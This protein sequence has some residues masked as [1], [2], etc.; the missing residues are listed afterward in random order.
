MRLL[1]ACSALVFLFGAVTAAWGAAPASV[2]TPAAATQLKRGDMVRVLRPQALFFYGKP[3][4]TAKAGA[5]MEVLDV[6]PATRQI[7][8]AVK[9][10]DRVIAVSLPLDAVRSEKEAVKTERVEQSTA[11]F[12]GL[13]PTLNVQLSAE[14]LESLRKEP[15][16][17]V[18]GTIEEAGVGPHEHLGIKLKGSAGSFQQVDQRPGFSINCSKFDGGSRFHGLRRFQLNNSVQDGTVLNELVSGEMA[19]AAGIPASRCT[20]ALVSINGRA[21][22][23]YVLKEGFTE[24]FLSTFFKQTDGHLY[25]GGFVADIQD[26]MELDRGDPENQ[27]ALARLNTALKE[28]DPAKQFELLKQVV[29]VDAYLRYLAMEDILCHWDG[30]SYNRNNYRI[31]ENPETGRFCFILH[32]MDQVFGDAKMSLERPPVAAVGAALWRRPELRAR[33]WADLQDIYARVIKPVN[34]PARVQ[35]HGR[36]L[37]AALPKDKANEY[38]PRITEASDHVAA[39]LAEV[40][41]LL[42]TPRL[43]PI[44]ATKGAAELKTGSWISQAEN[45][46]ANEVVEDRHPSLH[47]KATGDATAS[48]RLTLA[49]PAGKF[50]FTARMKTR[51]VEVAPSETGAGLRISGG[52]PQGQRELQGTVAWQTLTCDFDS[53]GSDVTLVAELRAKAGEVWIDKESLRL[54]RLP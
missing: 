4:G 51:G 30:Y 27:E 8:V 3:W 14:A 54:A 52:S 46:E 43:E 29:D 12:A 23:I 19:R 22:G 17:Y 11:L 21:L 18:E 16:K 44:L 7:F 50:R 39:R 31:Y 48:W 6:R 24:E 25:D 33:Y 37:Q 15:K 40:K 34:W 26:K 47:L 13:I 10:G 9:D 35:E 32:G 42:E 36:R 53:T 49:A 2:A 41:R 20:H 28:G 1:P 5:V 38:K 45:A